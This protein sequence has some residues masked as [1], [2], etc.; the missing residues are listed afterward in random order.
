VCGSQLNAAKR[1]NDGVELI[2]T[3]TDAARVRS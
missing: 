3:S 1:V 2:K